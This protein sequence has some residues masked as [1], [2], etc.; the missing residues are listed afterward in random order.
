MNYI[1]KAMI[2]VST[3]GAV[4]IAIATPEVGNVTMTQNAMSGRLVTITYTLTEDAVVTLD[5]MT[6]A[7]PNAATGWASI[8]GEAICNAQG[9]VWRKVTS[10]EA[11]GQGKHTITWRPDNSWT[12]ELGRGFKVAD[13][14]AKAVVTAWA[15]DNT[16]NYMVVDLAVNNTVRYYPSVDFLPG[17]EIGQKGAVTNNASYK[18][19]KLLMR[20]IMAAGVE[21]TMG[22]AASETLRNANETAHVVTLTNNYYIGVFEMTQTQWKNVAPGS[23]AAARF[24][25]DGAMRPMEQVSYNE[26]RNNA[27]STAVNA[28]YNW[29]AAPNPNSFLGLLRA[30][31][32][33]DFDLPSEAQWEFAA[34]AGNGS[35]FWNDGSAVMNLH[36]DDTNL[37]RLGRFRTNNPGGNATTATFAPTAGGTAVVGSYAP[38]AW[39]LYDMH[40][41][42]FEW[43]LDFFEADITGNDGKV[44]I[45]PVNSTKTLSGVAVSDRVLRSGWYGNTATDCRSANRISFGPENRT[46]HTGFRVICTA[47]LR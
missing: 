27:N 42:V 40:G 16:P 6:N 47:G 34:R 46:H 12:D 28:S 1:K 29:P 37:M 41:N 35:G 20:K 30:K 3:A 43:C 25:V 33:L 19:T 17:S 10:A 2:F 9:A 21:W 11:D 24:P 4:A 45:D 15:L 39:G 5:V 26:I 14:C 44:N 22:S 31:T 38:S 7:T 8:G 32:G 13:G 18:T 36:W 23:S